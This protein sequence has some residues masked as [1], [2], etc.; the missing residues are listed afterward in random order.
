MTW[1]F[2]IGRTRTL[3]AALTAMLAL[4]GACEKA[5][6][7]GKPSSS[8][9]TMPPVRGAAYVMIALD[10]S[11]SRSSEEVTGDRTLIGKVVDRLTFGDTVAILDVCASGRPE[12][13]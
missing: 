13:C 7:A 2:V 3:P 1:R 4:L 8:S 11:T 10:R 6:G 9:A 5:P 12:A